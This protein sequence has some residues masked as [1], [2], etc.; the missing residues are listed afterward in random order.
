MGMNEQ[1]G[2]MYDWITHTWNTI[3][4]I[5]SHDC[6]YCYMKV[7]NLKEV[8]F[9]WM[10]LKTNLGYN[11]Y[12]FVGSSCDDFARDISK[13]WIDRT[14]EHCCK[15]NQNRYLFQSK[16]PARFIKFLQKMPDNILLATTLETNRDNIV[17]NY[18]K[19]PSIQERVKAMKRLKKRNLFTMISIEPVMKFDYDEFYDMIYSCDPDFVS[20]GGDS[21]RHI[22]P[23]PD[24]K[25]LWELINALKT[26][27]EVKVKDNLKRMIK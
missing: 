26:F 25:S 21:K 16:N 9:D 22:I 6:D 12:I 27:T 24:R 17:R 4:G 3:K 14:L 13:E 2:N 10:E 23:E 20:I 11:N 1:K 5:C 19:A 8:R 15:Y 7:F 18:S